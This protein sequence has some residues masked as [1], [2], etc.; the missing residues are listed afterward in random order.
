MCRLRPLVLRFF[1]SPWD[2]GGW[3]SCLMSPPQQ[4]C[5]VPGAS[6]QG[7]LIPF[8][9]S[10]STFP[11]GGR[12]ATERSKN[13]VGFCF[14]LSET[15]CSRWTC[16]LRRYDRDLF[17]EAVRVSTGLRNSI[18]GTLSN[19]CCLPLVLHTD[20]AG[21]FLS[22]SF[23]TLRPA[24]PSFFLSSFWDGGSCRRVLSGMT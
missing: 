15:W 13:Y 9:L 12:E 16:A 11:G 14:S 10:R 18:R 8:F 2:Q 19:V 1:C 5:H 6:S 7:L 20:M 22:M 4:C 17:P 23:G 3:I 21:P 24:S